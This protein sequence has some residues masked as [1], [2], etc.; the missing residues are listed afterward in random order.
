[1][2]LNS[3][4]IERTPLAVLMALALV[5]PGILLAGLAA[6]VYFAVAWLPAVRIKASVELSS[7]DPN[8]TRWARFGVMIEVLLV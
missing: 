6:L 2:T 8:E 4:E 1:M 5:L 3:P 7:D